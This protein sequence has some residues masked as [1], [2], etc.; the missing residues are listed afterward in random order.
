[1][2][3]TAHPLETSMTLEGFMELA[4]LSRELRRFPFD[5]AT[6]I[7]H[8]RDGDHVVG[9]V[10]YG[11]ANGNGSIG[12]GWSSSDGGNRTTVFDPASWKGRVRENVVFFGRV[13]QD[14]SDADVPWKE[15]DL[16]AVVASRR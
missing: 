2:R 8:R 9:R 16:Y 11:G 14:A 13:A 10:E 6:I 3:D 4:Q 1:M 7:E 5:G 12:I 15:S